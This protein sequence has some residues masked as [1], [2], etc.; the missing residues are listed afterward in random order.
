M[1]VE[2]N[3]KNSWLYFEY[4]SSLYFFLVNLKLHIIQAKYSGTVKS[5]CSLYWLFNILLF[6][7]DR[8]HLWLEAY[9]T[10]GRIKKSNV[11]EFTTKPGVIPASDSLQGQYKVWP[12][13]IKKT[14]FV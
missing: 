8:Y 13:C 9:L 14:V 11:K 5:S 12:P 2:S 10:N 3:D 6:D 4:S 7:Y 1:Q